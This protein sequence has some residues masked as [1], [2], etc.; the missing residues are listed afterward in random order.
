MNIH[1]YVIIGAGPAGLQM[2]YFLGK[3]QRDYVVLEAASTAGSFFLEQ[4]RHRTL[5][6]INKRFNYYPEAEYN[7]RHDWNSLL[8][9]DFSHLFR[10]YSQD[11]FP[12]AD[13]IVRYLE[14]FAERFAI[15]IAY[16][17]RV[18]QVARRGD[19]D[20][21]VLT[22]VTGQQWGARVLLVGTGPV[23]PHIPEEIVGIELAEGYEDHT[24][25]PTAYENQ[26]VLIIGAGN[27]GFEVAN[28]LAGHAA[29]IHIALGDRLVRHAWQTHYVGD[30]RAINNTVL[31]MYQ[32]K[33]L[34]ATLAA[35]VKRIERRP[36]GAFEVHCQNNLAH[37][38]H[39]GRI[40]YAFTYDRVIRCT[41]W[42]FVAPEIFAP[43][44]TPQL[45]ANGKYPALSSCWETSVPD[46]FYIGTAMGCLD[47]KSASSFIH[48]FRYNI[49]TLFHLLEERY[50]SVPLPT[51]VLPLRTKDDLA[52]LAQHLVKRL[53]TTSALYQL[54]E[55]FC[56]VLVCKD[57]Q[58]EI[59][60]ELPADYVLDT[61]QF[62][63]DVE[64]VT[65]SFRYGFH[66]YPAG[67]NTLDFVH[68]PSS[69]DCSAFLHG[70]LRHFVNGE[71]TRETPMDESL[72]IRYDTTFR[73]FGG[74]GVPVLMNFLNAVWPV[75]EDEI[76]VPFSG[77]IEFTPWPPSQEKVGV[78]IPG[79]TKE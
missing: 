8:T 22:D 23:R 14:D 70:V 30:L 63:E 44:V 28:H 67:A 13:A 47:H 60:Q 9:D 7:L 48:G 52:A 10:E 78:D 50:Q 35:C 25:D 16:N 1:D 39:P 64:I 17:R 6:S 79:C 53:S 75:T 62:T 19:D 66:N 18:T 51:T 55:F 24:L 33:S 5:L 49:R 31:D 41:G 38:K 45:H 32:L 26:R 40:R 42:K 68:P 74:D 15:N 27:S 65:V 77:D 61:S 54:F 12:H 36:D 46:M 34:H 21:F 72:L 57:G 11:L 71:M 2:G 29:V 56:D 37:W 58:V 73:E 43:E 59:Y 4:P 3:A 69:T 76:P 20:L